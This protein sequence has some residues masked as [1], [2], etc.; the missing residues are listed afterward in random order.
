MRIQSSELAMQSQH[1]SLSV[2]QRQTSLKIWQEAPSQGEAPA[3]QGVADSVRRPHPVGLAHGLHGDMPAWGRGDKTA[4]S[5]KTEKADKDAALPPDVARMKQAIESLMAWLTGRSIRM[6]I[7][8]SDDLKPKAEGGTAASVPAQGQVH[9]QMSAAN[10]PAWGME[11]KAS[12]SYFEAE[13]LSVGMAG[14]VTTGDGR[15]IEFSLSMSLSRMH[16]SQQSLEMRA[17]AALKDPLVVN[18][19]GSAA[20]LQVE[21]FAFDLEGRGDA[22]S[23]SLFSLEAGSGYLALDRNDN[24]QIDDGSELFGPASGNGF[25]DLTRLD[26]D[27]NGW[28]DEADAAF[29][30]LQV[31]LPDAQGKG[32]LL[33]LGKLGI[34]ALHTGAVDA[35]FE[36]RDAGNDLQGKMQ[37]AGVFLFEDGRA[38]SLQ[39]I[40][41]VA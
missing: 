19:G 2:H 24:G 33:G 39:Q 5:A 22:G 12:E 37:R 15:A 38:G 30:R 40:D 34:G 29:A 20:R 6:D 7:F 35:P 16:Y 8:S 28:I 41:M 14:K 26:D 21:R 1:A 10:E 32:E 31:W 9:S 3:Q 13:M 27:G 25:A 36:Y 23:G 4:D 11:F 18:F 17:G